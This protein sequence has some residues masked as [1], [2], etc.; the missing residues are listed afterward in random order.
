MRV[1]LGYCIS[2]IADIVAWCG[3]GI[4]NKL[5]LKVL[6]IQIYIANIKLEVEEHKS[7]SKF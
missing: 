6:E 7:V 2:L 3:I 5:C 4:P 1:R